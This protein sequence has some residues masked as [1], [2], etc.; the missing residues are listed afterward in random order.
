MPFN[1]RNRNFLRSLTVL[2]FRLGKPLKRL[3]KGAVMA[4]ITGANIQKT[5]QVL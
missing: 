3:E 1:K 2:A 4:V 5:V